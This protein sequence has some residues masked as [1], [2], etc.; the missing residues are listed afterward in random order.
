MVIRAQGSTF[1]VAG[2]A[3]VNT[4]HRRYLRRGLVPLQNLTLND[5]FHVHGCVA[6]HIESVPRCTD[7]HYFERCLGP[8]PILIKELWGSVN[9]FHEAITLFTI[10]G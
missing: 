8:M 5:A 1:N 6:S 4:K 7:Y 3:P 9:L 10:S 2:Y